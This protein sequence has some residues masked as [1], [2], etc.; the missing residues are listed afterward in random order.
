[1]RTPAA[2]TTSPSRRGGAS[3]QNSG[4]A[5]RDGA[6]VSA[7]NRAS[8]PVWSAWRWATSTSS[9]GPASARVARC[10]S[11]SGPGSTTTQPGAPVARSTY[12]RVPSSV[13]GPGLSA[14]STAAK[15][16]TGST[17]SLWPGGSARGDGGEGLFQV[18]DEVERVLQA[19]RQADRR[20]RDADG[21]SPGRA[22]LAVR[23]GGRVGDEGLRVAE[24]VRDVDDAQ[25]VEEREGA[26]LRLVGVAALGHGEVERHDRAAAAHLCAREVGL[27]VGV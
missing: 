10:G 26:L 23:R 19:H 3:A 20:L 12:E 16:A 15:G 22:E 14:R 8:P 6:P 7:R 27:R 18:L 17:G 21:R 1:M 5:P 13:I 11:R 24:V 4:D 25:R 9:T 2:S